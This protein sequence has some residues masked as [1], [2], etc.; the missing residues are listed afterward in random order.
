MKVKV[1]LKDSERKNTLECYKRQKYIKL[2]HNCKYHAFIFLNIFNCLIFI[3]YTTYRKQVYLLKKLLNITCSRNYSTIH[4]V[5]P[6]D[7]NLTKYKYENY[8]IMW[9]RFRVFF[10]LQKYIIYFNKCT[11]NLH[12]YLFPSMFFVLRYLW[13]LSS[14]LK[15]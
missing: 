9:E 14:L 1:Y 4:Y 8:K 7:S 10:S 13:I 15:Y 3:V 6:T 11:L 2:F 12:L 5:C